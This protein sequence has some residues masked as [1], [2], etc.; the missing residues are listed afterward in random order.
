MMPI[1]IIPKPMW[2]SDPPASLKVDFLSNL[3]KMNALAT[4]VNIPVNTMMMYFQS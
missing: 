3:I 1:K 4:I 2:A